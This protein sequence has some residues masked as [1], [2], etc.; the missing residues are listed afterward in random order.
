MTS[1]NAS[2]AS[3]EE[4]FS[5]Y[6]QTVSIQL[7]CWRAAA[8]ARGVV[9][10]LKKKHYIFLRASTRYW[11]GRRHSCSLKCTSFIRRLLTASPRGPAQP[12]N[13][14]SFTQQGCRPLGR[15]PDLHQL[16]GDGR[17]GR[18][19][20][21]RGAAHALRRYVRPGPDIF[22]ESDLAKIFCTCVNEFTN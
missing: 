21:V 17:E 8:R 6:C 22:V 9:Y 3:R 19:R 11:E 12:L 5:L 16:P 1:S 13:I 20:P 15:E 4:C 7:C 18:G 10:C 14:E 2:T